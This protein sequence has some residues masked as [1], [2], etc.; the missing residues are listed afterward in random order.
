MSLEPQAALE[1]AVLHF[2]TLDTVSG[3]LAYGAKFCGR[4]YKGYPPM[5]CPIWYAAVWGDGAVQSGTNRA[6][7]SALDETYS[8][9]VTLT[10]PCSLPF[11]RWI[12]H[13]DF[14]EEKRN[15]IRALI[16]E[17]AYN[18]AII[19]RANTLGEMRR[20]DLAS[21]ATQPVGFWQGLAWDGADPIQEAGPDW[22]QGDPEA[23]NPKVGLT[24]RLRFVGAC[25]M[26]DGA[27][28]E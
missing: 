8:V 7:R 26:Q 19:N 1:S 2:L 3:G 23:A 11:D 15:R 28:M 13:Q 12:E 6:T 27:N 24:Q 18:C 14:L 17:D 16:H 20:A 4:R 21:G 9:Y 10:V 5:L 25:R 22:F